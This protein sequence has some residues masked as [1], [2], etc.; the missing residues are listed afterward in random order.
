[1]VFKVVGGVAPEDVDNLWASTD[2]VSENMNAALDVTTAHQEHYKNRIIQNWEAFN[3]REVCL[4]SYKMLK[5]KLKATIRTKQ[6]RDPSCIFL[7]MSKE[8]KSNY[9]FLF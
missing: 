3:P 5:W 2:T 1:M 7:S 6:I 4:Y 8:V 9:Y